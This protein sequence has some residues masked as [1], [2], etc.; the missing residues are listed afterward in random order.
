MNILIGND[1]YMYVWR[2]EEKFFKTE[3][4]YHIQSFHMK[5]IKLIEGMFN[6]FQMKWPAV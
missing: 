3:L 6:K 4:V 2:L 5:F 1:N